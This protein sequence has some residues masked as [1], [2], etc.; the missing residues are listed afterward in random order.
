[1]S[2]PITLPSPPVAIAPIQLAEAVAD[3]FGPAGTASDVCLDTSL[4][5][6][7]WQPSIVWASSPTSTGTSGL[8]G[9]AVNGVTIETGPAGPSS[10]LKVSI[11]NNPSTVAHDAHADGHE[12]P[13][14]HDAGQGADLPDRLRLRAVRH[15]QL[16][17]QPRER[18]DVRHDRLLL[19]PEHEHHAADRREPRRRRPSRASPAP[20]ASTLPTR[21]RRPASPA[22]ARRAPS[23]SLARMGSL[24]RSPAR[25]SRPPRAPLC[26]SPGPA[27]LDPRTLAEI[28]RVLTA[29]K[30]VFLLGGTAAL[31]TSVQTAPDRRP[32][33]RSFGSRASIA[34]TRQCAS[35]AT[36]STTRRRCW[37]PTA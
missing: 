37:S 10:R 18:H 7:S 12:D 23:C 14:G 11:Q 13:T 26:C 15:A 34:S 20:I 2:A 33:T 19:E 35:R 36:V 4:N 32:A 29:G 28:Q 22:S 16:G 8:G 17:R 1:M 30:T 3:A 9:D 21:S 24:T 31:S 5:S 27:S 25:R 6:T